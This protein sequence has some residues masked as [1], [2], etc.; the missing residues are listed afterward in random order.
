MKWGDCVTVGFMNPPIDDRECYEPT[1][2]N[3]CGAEYDRAL[4]GNACPECGGTD[5]DEDGGEE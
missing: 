4:E 2:C 1:A 5:Y 3:W